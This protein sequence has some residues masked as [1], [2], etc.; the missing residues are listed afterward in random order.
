[1]IALRSSGVSASQ[2]QSY[3]QSAWMREVEYQLTA[4]PLRYAAW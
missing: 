3:A 2:I 4:R 1:M